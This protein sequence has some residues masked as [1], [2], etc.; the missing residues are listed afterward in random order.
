M[1]STP[2]MAGFALGLVWTARPVA[3]PLFIDRFAHTQDVAVTAPA[4]AG[5]VTAVKRIVVPMMALL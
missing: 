5:T 2:P 1:R 3:L 4:L